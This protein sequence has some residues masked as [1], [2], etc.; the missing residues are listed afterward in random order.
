MYAGDCRLM[1]PVPLSGG[2]EPGARTGTSVNGLPVVV[3]RGAATAHLV[4]TDAGAAQRQGLPA[5]PGPG[6]SW[7]APL[8]SPRFAS[9][10]ARLLALFTTE[11]APP[12]LVE[13]ACI[14]ATPS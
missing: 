12:G 13:E 10:Q 5:S 8:T 4:N 14:P 11:D 6:D 9:R 3:W 2:V 7:L 1:I